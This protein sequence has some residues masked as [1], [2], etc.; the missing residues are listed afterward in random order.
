MLIKNFPDV[1]KLLGNSDARS[2]R[3]SQLLD[4]HIVPLTAFVEE[5]RTLRGATE[6]I[7]NFDPWD[8]GVEAEILFLL[9]AP[10]RKAVESC[11]VSR[12]NPDETAKNFFELNAEAGIPRKRTV[13]WNIVPWYIGS[14]TKIRPARRVDI[15]DGIQSL[16]YLLKLLPKLQAV[17]LVGRK[18]EHAGEDIVRINSRLYV[19]RSPHPSPLFINHAPENRERILKVLR[20][21]AAQLPLTQA[22]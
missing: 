8:G 14:G 2:E 4:P 1:P 7:P 22:G 12:N 11:F 6:R 20:E 10:G 17:V 5:L 9:E 18:A 3:A 15:D 19:H 13:V 21:V 16:G